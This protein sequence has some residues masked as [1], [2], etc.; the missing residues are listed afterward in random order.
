MVTGGGGKRSG[1]WVTVCY[2]R[3][4]S[5][6]GRG[7]NAEGSGKPD[8]SVALLLLIYAKTTEC[9]LDVLTVL[10]VLLSQKHCSAFGEHQ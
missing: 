10:F 4:P 1:R 3:E 6:E 5:A 8:S 2:G 9:G 7:Q